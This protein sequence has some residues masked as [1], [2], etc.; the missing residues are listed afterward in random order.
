MRSRDKNKCNQIFTTYL[1][2]MVSLY[3]G[4]ILIKI[5]TNGAW[6]REEKKRKTE[7]TEV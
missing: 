3:S 5:N 4:V 7:Y 6:K 1:L 2:V